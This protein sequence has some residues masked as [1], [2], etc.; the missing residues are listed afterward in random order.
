MLYEIAH[1]IKDRFG[2]VWE[3]VEWVNATL[4][5]LM[6]RSEL[7]D[8]PDVLNLISNE[9]FVIRMTVD[10]DAPVLAKF[11]SEQPK[12]AFEFFHPHAF[13]ARSIRKIIK[14]KAFQTFV[15]IDKNAKGDALVGYFFLRSFVNGKCFRGRIAD[16]RTRGK[17]VGKL[18]ARA[19]ENVAVHEGLRMFASISPDNYASLNSAKAVSEVKVIK[20]LENGYYYIEVMPRKE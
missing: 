9:A 1:V 17:G 11:F 5:G 12:E 15:V 14:N 7:K 3:I 16:Y 20:T 4:F 13:D 19:L 2:F 6:Y 8:V 10:E 18:M